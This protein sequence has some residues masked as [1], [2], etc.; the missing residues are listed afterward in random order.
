METSFQKHVSLNAWQLEILTCKS[1]GFKS[2]S[3]ES[4]ALL[5]SH[6]ILTGIGKAS[7]LWRF[8]WWCVCGMTVVHVGVGETM[9]M[10][11]RA[12]VR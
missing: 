7:G 4:K 11:T 3:F 5:L 12:W 6:L 10:M 1:S 9:K 8:G 2:V